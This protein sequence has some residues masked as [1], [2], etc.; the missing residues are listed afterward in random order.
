[1][2]KKMFIAD[3]EEIGDSFIGII[4]QGELSKTRFAEDNFGNFAIIEDDGS[5]VAYML[6]Y[7]K[8]EYELAESKEDFY[9][10]Y[11][12]YDIE[13]VYDILNKRRKNEKIEEEYD[14]ITELYKAKAVIGKDFIDLTYVVDDNKYNA[15]SAYNHGKI[16]EDEL[17]K[18]KNFGPE[19]L[20]EANKV[21]KEKHNRELKD[22]NSE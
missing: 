3:I 6:D 9:S 5:I 4:C 21:N 1:M 16:S 8:E 13:E 11:T 7:E 18:L 20:K 14:F 10:K 17:K 15:T 12:L 2:I 22:D 19:Y